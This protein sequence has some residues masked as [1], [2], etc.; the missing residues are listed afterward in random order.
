[1]EEETLDSGDNRHK[2]EG[3]KESEM[4]GIL[5]LCDRERGDINIHQQARQA[6]ELLQ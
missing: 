5:N 2:V 6:V 1:M 3:R 4:T